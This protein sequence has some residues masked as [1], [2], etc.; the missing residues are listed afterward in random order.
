MRLE[1]RLEL[2]KRITQLDS[3]IKADTATLAS[4]RHNLNAITRQ[5][6]EGEDRL[7][8]KVATRAA[9]DA[10]FQE[11]MKDKRAGEP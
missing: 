7:A 4:L 9:M 8:G 6:K 2:K 3:E 11:A 10:D 1:T 5:V